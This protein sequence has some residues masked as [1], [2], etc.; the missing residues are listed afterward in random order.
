MK[1]FL[2]CIIYGIRKTGGIVVYTD[3]L[4][5]S[6][7]RHNVDYVASSKDVNFFDK[8]VG[9]Y[10]PSQVPRQSFDVFH[11][12]YYRVP[13]RRVPTVVTVHDFIY[14]KLFSGVK[15]KV[16]S[17]QKFKSIYS[18]DAIICVSH[19]TKADLLEYTHGR[20]DEKNIHVIHNGVSESF[21]YLNS[22]DSHDSYAL[23]VGKRDGYKNFKLAVDAV[24]RI[25]GLK[26]I[27][28][29]G[30]EFSREEVNYL[31]EENIGTKFINYPVVSEERLNQLYNGAVCLLYMSS[32]EGFGIP[33]IE[34]MRAGCPVI[35]IPCKAIAEIAHGASITVADF[36]SVEN[37]ADAVI[38]CS[39]SGR[40]EIIKKG[41]DVSSHYSWSRT[42][43][44]TIDVYRTLC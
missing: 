15:R 34:A 5:N 6:L 42:H 26:L 20:L 40:E 17:W 37:I 27:S 18:A 3:E 10:L 8:Y 41:F 28:V 4:I 13:S 32:Y 39:G 43:S 44:E 25:D 19:A 38:Q 11:S 1:V 22:Y 9:R 29:G 24:R 16:H 23:F 33:V 21:T 7:K 12:S 14:E 30:G 31:G 2:D 36:L 35:N